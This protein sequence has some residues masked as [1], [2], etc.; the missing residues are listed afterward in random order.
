MKPVNITSTDNI[1]CMCSSKSRE[2]INEHKVSFLC[3]LCKDAHIL[4]DKPNLHLLS[5]QLRENIVNDIINNT[6]FTTDVKISW[7]K[8]ANVPYSD[9]TFDNIFRQFLYKRFID[10]TI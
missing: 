2:T 4:I 3:R 1:N 8:G 9:E 6:T 5:L 10:F 7:C